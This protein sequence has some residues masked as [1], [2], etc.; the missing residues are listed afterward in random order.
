MFALRILLRPGEAM[1]PILRA[2]CGALVGVGIYWV[3][4]LVKELRYLYW[5]HYYDWEGVFRECMFPLM[6]PA[7]L[8]RDTWHDGPIWAN[9]EM[10]A[11]VIVIIGGG[12]LGAGV[13]S[14]G[15][16]RQGGE[17]KGAT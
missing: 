3:F 9:L 5:G 1:K 8:S 4:I 14:R 7:L 6:S 10:L 17:G 2:V 16:R 13:K 15:I 11:S 12:I